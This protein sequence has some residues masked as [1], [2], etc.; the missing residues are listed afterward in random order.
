M[1]RD[2][3]I[4]RAQRR[5]HVSMDLY[6]RR[7]PLKGFC[8]AEVRF[9]SPRIE[10]KRDSRKGMSFF[11]T[12]W[13]ARRQTS[14]QG[15]IVDW[16]LGIRRPNNCPLSLNNATFESRFRPAITG[17]PL[18]RG[19][20]GRTK[21]RTAITS[22]RNA[23]R[24]KS[25]VLWLRCSFGSG[26]VVLL[27]LRLLQRRQIHVARW[28]LGCSS[29]EV[30]WQGLGFH[31]QQTVTKAGPIGRA[32]KM[33]F[34]FFDSEAL[35]SGVVAWNHSLVRPQCWIDTLQGRPRP[36]WVTRDN[37]GKSSDGRIWLARRY[38]QVTIQNPSKDDWCSGL[39]MLCWSK[40]AAI[41][42][43]SW[44]QRAGTP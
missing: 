1:P 16:S 34:K 25:H 27:S 9:S 31:F 35:K 20:W 19:F 24:K 43:A 11:T 42:R 29:A 26:R 4:Q 41:K 12:R 44:S 13:A 38:N 3:S 6:G 5:F 15:V 37:G 36:L 8:L 7:T 39:F 23:S 17:D 30:I 18:I 10:F 28:V 32:S 22:E 14:A 33:F 40:L 2:G 21:G